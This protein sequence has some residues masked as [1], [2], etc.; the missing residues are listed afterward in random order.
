VLGKTAMNRSASGEVVHVSD[1]GRVV[2]F[3]AALTDADSPG[4]RAQR[5]CRRLDR[6]NASKRS[7]L[8][9]LILRDGQQ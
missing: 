8:W 7:Y 4:E 6:V 1:N 9:R 2:F 5:I 3:A